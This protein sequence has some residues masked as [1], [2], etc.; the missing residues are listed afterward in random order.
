MNS[1]LITYDLKNGTPSRYDEL[2]GKIKSLGSW[3]HYLES[4]WILKNT[5]YINANDINKELIPYIDQTTDRLLVI[6]ID[7]KNKQGWLPQ[8]AW[9]W[10][11]Q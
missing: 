2:R 3:W 1:Y 5:S 4:T 11:N 6:K 8:K 9:E 10:L 7:L